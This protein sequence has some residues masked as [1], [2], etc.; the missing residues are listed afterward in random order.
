MIPMRDSIRSRR[1]PVVNLALIAANVLVF[2]Y[3]SALSQGELRAF[4]MRFGLIPIQITMVPRFL[5]AGRPEFAVQALGTFVT[6]T[7]LHGGLLHLGG[8]MLYLWVFGDNVEDRLGRWR[9]LLFY[10]VTGTIASMAHMY[11]DPTSRLPLIG[12]SGAVAGVLGAYFITFPRSRV[13]ALVPL[14]FF[15]HLAEVPAVIFLALW[16][17][18]QL[19]YGL[20]SLAPGAADMVAWWAHVGGFAA[21]VVLMRLLDRRR[22]SGRLRSEDSGPGGAGS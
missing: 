20:G 4:I 9:Y 6:S 5:A 7:F 11:Y 10:L 17:V 2:L 14:F 12:A 18:L 16:F 13:L 22:G 1:L 19:A 21:G 15:L 8:N 3:Q